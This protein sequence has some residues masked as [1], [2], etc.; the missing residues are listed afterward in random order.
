[1]GEPEVLRLAADILEKRFQS[2]VKDAK[3]KTITAE[4]AMDLAGCGLM[5]HMTELLRELADTF[6]CSVRSK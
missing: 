2:T 3:G 6:P 5:H 1:M 4:I